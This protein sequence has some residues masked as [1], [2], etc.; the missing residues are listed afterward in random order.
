MGIYDPLKGFLA[1]QV[2][3][4]AVLSFG[5][6]ETIL[7]HKLPSAAHEHDWWW[8]NEDVLTTQ[9]VQCKS[10]QGAG[11]Q[12]AAVDRAHRSVRFTR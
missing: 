12:M 10:W 5:Q 8:A 2:G 3:R 6:I 7:S 9:H 4:V 11:W 1:G